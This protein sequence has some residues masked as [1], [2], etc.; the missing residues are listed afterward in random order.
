MNIEI[1][2]K[3]DIILEKWYQTYP[4]KSRADVSFFI[5]LIILVL[6]G[7]LMVVSASSVIGYSSFGDSFHFVKQHLAFMLLGSVAFVVGYVVPHPIWR[8]FALN[9]WILSLGLICLTFIPSF[10]VTLG[11]ATRWLNFFGFQFQPSEILKFTLIL[12]LADYF[13]TNRDQLTDNKT[14]ILG[15]GIIGIS[16]LLVLK[17]PDLGTTIVI[18]GTAAG[19]LLVA[20]LPL[21]LFSLIGVVGAFLAVVNIRMNPYQMNRIHAWVDP[22][23]DPFGKG[24]HTI[25]SL[26]AVGTGGLFGLGLGQSR[27]KFFYLPQQ[28][29]DYIFSIVCEEFGFIF[30]VLFLLLYLFFIFRGFILSAKTPLLFSKLLGVGLM[31]WITVQAIMNIGVTINLVPPTGITLPFISYGGTSLLMLLFSSGVMLN[32]SRYRENLQ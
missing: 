5:S 29:T 31:L 23:A 20:G 25:Q 16:L 12:Y 13:D 3:E 19:I 18:A 21:I 2:R 11:G 27:Q 4:P 7:L 9:M 26:I 6:F 8:K 30:T 14:L 17:Q 32:I 22:W 10:G 15:L 24:F 1:L 28:Y